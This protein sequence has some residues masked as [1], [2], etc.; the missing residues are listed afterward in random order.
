MILQEFYS[1]IY[2]ILRLIC[3]GSISIRDINIL[4]V[5]INFNIIL[6]TSTANDLSRIKISSSILRP[7]LSSTHLVCPPLGPEVFLM[8]T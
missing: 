7:I 1:T 4:N 3:S 5:D 6:F 8:V 2:P